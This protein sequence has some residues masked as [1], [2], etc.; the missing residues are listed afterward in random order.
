M[1]HSRVAVLVEQNKPLVLAEIELPLLQVG[2]VL[3][4]VA[5]SGICGSQIGE[6]TG[7]RGHDKYLPHLLGHEGS[8]I[9][10][11]VGLGVKKVKPGDRVVLHWVKGSG[12]DTSGPKLEWNGEG[13]NAG[14]ITTFSEYTIVPENRVTPI[15]IGLRC[16]ALLGCAVTTGLGIVFN[17]IKLKP[18]ESIAVFGVG[19]I[20]LN[21]VHGA[22][23]VNAHP[24]VAIDIHQSKLDHAGLFGATHAAQSWDEGV[25]VV[26]DT[27][28]YPGVFEQ[29]YKL[30]AK[31]AVVIGVRQEPIVIDA[32]PLNHGKQLIGS[33]GGGTNPD[34]DIPRYAKLYRLGKLKLGEQITHEYGLEAI[35]EAIES[36][37]S[38][39]AGKCLIRM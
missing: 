26:V 3:V 7:V 1:V 17:D 27:T 35:N 23:M 33:H 11:N 10:Q 6:I 21:V 9:V 15:N 38:G 31:K 2:Q 24:I 34:V 8:G 20:G 30:A 28:A 16:A 37:R 25:D 39:E 29:A 13:L 36:V 14:P 12:I 22:A 19:S 4:K 5:Y 18:G 32:L